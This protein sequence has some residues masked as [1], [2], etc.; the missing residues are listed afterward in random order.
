MFGPQ[1]FANNSLGSIMA[2]GGFGCSCKICGRKIAAPHK[3][4]GAVVW[5]LYCGM[6]RGFVPLVEIPGGLEYSNGI[7]REECD[8]VSANVARLDE[9]AMDRA[10]D[11]GAFCL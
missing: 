5:C 2:G 3:F 11:L 1:F 6:E 8:M 9:W 4:Q 10:H 7:T